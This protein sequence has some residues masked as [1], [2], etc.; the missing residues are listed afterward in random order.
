ME[1]TSKSSEDTKNIGKALGNLAFPSMIIALIGDMGA[2]KTEFTK[3]F[4]KG[5]HKDNMA[6]SPTFTV[7]NVYEK[8]NIPVYHFDFYKTQGEIGDEFDEYI[9]G[10]GVAIIEWASLVPLSKDILEIRFE[11]I[12]ENVRNLKFSFNGVKYQ[13]IMEKLMGERK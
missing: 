2:G 11:T 10:D 12:D 7:M 6:K 1:F 9:Y 5:V 4:V 8:G 3:G 13:E